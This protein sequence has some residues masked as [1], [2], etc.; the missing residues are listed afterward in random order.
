MN[1]DEFCSLPP[2][3]ALGLL[4]DA[5]AKELVNVPVPKLPSPPKFDTRISRKGGMFVWASEMLLNDLKFWHERN[6]A[7]ATDG[8][9]YAE[10]NAKMAKALE[11]WIKWRIA[12]PTD[13]WFGERSQGRAT[14]KVRAN[15]PSRD[16]EQY[17]W[18]R[19]GGDGSSS[20]PA[21]GGFA[22][23]DGAGGGDDDIPF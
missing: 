1:R 12:Y 15:P 23:A 8:S 9:Q 19:S 7:G 10:K 14:V 20:K 13:V 5:Y 4:Y 16:P 11:Y 18:E 3:V 17:P 6:A 2:S 21:G 22:D